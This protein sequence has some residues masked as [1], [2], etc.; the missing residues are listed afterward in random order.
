MIEN[1]ISNKI[2][3]EE[4]QSKIQSYAWENAD[5]VIAQAI[6]HEIESK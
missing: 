4:M 1:L 5:Q 2:I 6:I 3:L